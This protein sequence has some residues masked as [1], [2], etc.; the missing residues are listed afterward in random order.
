M[1]AAERSYLLL[2]LELKDLSGEVFALG[3]HYDV[4][5][6]SGNIWFTA[7]L[8]GTGEEPSPPHYYGKKALF[9]RERKRS[10]LL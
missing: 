9:P 8:M 7:T 1:Y 2:T 10:W 6:I 3:I 5:I 4:I